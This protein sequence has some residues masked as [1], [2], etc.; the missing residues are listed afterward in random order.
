MT[1][2][3]N[4][5]SERLEAA[6][7]R[8]TELASGASSRARDFIHDHPVASIAGG[9]AVGALI[10]GLLMPRKRPTLAKAGEAAI[11]ASAARLGR[12]A[13]LGA[14]LALAYA[15]RAASASKEG[16]GKIED[17]IVDQ[18]G[19]INDNGAEVGRKLSGLAEVALNTL[20]EAGEAAVHRLTHRE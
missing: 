12:L 18:L 10:A 15:A 20:R 14:E 2:Q 4:T 11:D 19:Q 1:D 8:S 5:L 13:S 3:D 6:R 9:I 17:R 7:E 16:A